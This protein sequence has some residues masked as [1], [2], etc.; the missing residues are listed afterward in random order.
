MDDVHLIGRASL[1]NSGLPQRLHDCQTLFADKCSDNSQEER[2]RPKVLKIFDQ[3]QVRNASNFFCLLVIEALSTTIGVGGIAVVTPATTNYTVA[4][5]AV[6]STE[7]RLGKGANGCYIFGVC[8]GTTYGG[9]LVVAQVFT[10]DK[11]E[12]ILFGLCGYWRM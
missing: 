4:T 5:L 1:G 11:V 12:V 6:T 7:L 9:A 2:H 10:I 8:V 3:D